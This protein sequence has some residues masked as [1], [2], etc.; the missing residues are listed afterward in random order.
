LKKSFLVLEV[1]EDKKRHPDYKFF[2]NVQCF[3][4]SSCKL[5]HELGNNQYKRG[6]DNEEYLEYQEQNLLHF[7]SK[8]KDM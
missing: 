6:A 7:I 1:F 8:L 3:V 2:R 4:I 5:L